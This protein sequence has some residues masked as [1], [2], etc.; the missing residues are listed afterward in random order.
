[1]ALVKETYR[2]QTAPRFYTREDLFALEE[3]PESLTAA[4]NLLAKRDCLDLALSALDQAR[5]IQTQGR[6]EEED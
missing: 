4:A 3:C 1:M 2:P 5:D 6:L